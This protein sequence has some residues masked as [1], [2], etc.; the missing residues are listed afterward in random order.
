MKQAIF[1]SVFKFVDSRVFWI[2][3]ALALRLVSVAKRSPRWL[4]LSGY[5]KERLG[6]LAAARTLYERALT[7][8]AVSNDTASLRWTQATQFFLERCKHCLGES[9]AAD[10]LF[11]C[12]AVPVQGETEPAGKPAGFFKVDFVFSGLRIMGNLPRGTE[13]S[14]SIM[15]DGVKI[16]DINV[17][18]GILSSAFTFKVTRSA[19]RLFPATATLTIRAAGGRPLRL[20]SGESAFSLFVPHG[21]AGSSPFIDGTRRLDKKGVPV[22]TLEEL[23]A[24][25]REFFAIYA[26]ARR[27]F[28]ERF[29]KHLFLAYGTLL[30]FHRAGDFI[31]GD[32]DFDTGFMAEATDPETVKLEVTEM[33]E[34]LTV[35]GFS[36]SFNRRGRL[37]RLHAR[38]AG[39]AGCHIDVH[40][41][42]AQNDRIWAHNDFC[43]CGTRE[44]FVPATERDFKGF[45]AFVPADPEAYL[46]AHYGPGWRVPDPGF[47]NTYEDKDPGVLAGL[48]KAL[49]APVEYKAAYAR[50]E[51]LRKAN[52]AIGEFV[53]LA[54]RS[55]YPLPDK[56]DDLE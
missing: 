31:P 56:D 1:F 39:I 51:A 53:S 34:A 6:D 23:A 52:P 16:R 10:P 49:I 11:F 33:V 41:F 32:D 14:V 35:E 22:P 48:A 12:Q 28:L 2:L 24:D 18:E 46:S 3:S 43:A 26:D 13:E 19:L 42:W 38:G 7:R 4:V 21:V 54:D 27:F 55:L 5:A 47:I 17:T 37:F 36:V 44:Q 50:L 15:L 25:R 29:G 45:T 30:G 8:I 20:F 9:C 40:S